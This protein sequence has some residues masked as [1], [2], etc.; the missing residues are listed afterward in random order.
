M[1]L[2]MRLTYDTDPVKVK[3][4]VKQIGL[5]MSE[6]PDLGPMLLD[7]PKSQGVL[8]MDDSAMILRVKFMAKPGEQFVLRRELLHRIRAAFARE[9]IHFAS[10]E[11]TVHVSGNAEDEKTKEA[12]AG[13][14]RRILDD[15][16]ERQQAAAAGAGDTR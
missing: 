12:A 15:E 5:E 8:Q 11:V 7:P 10:R 4:I 1:K 13:A 9:G 6:D 2:P 16:A 14:A 3:K